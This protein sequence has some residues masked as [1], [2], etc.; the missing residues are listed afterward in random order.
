[1]NV[2]EPSRTDVSIGQRTG[3]RQQFVVEPRT[4]LASEVL[5]RDRVS[6]HDAGMTSRDRRRLDLDHVIGSSTQNIRSFIK[7]DPCRVTEQPRGRPL[8]RH[9]PRGRLADQHLSG[10][11]VADAVYSAD[12]GRRSALINRV[13]DLVDQCLKAGFGDERVGPQLSVDVVLRDGFGTAL[14][15]EQQQVKRLPRQVQ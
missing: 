8:G 12:P 2:A 1:M 6:N 15:E 14:E 4:V 13:P 7:S 5:E 11:A 3:R 9:R 10:K